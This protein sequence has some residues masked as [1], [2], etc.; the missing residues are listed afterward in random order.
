MSSGKSNL[1]Q[2]MPP[3]SRRLITSTLRDVEQELSFTAGEN[4]KDSHFGRQFGFLTEL[5][6]L[7]YKPVIMLLVFLPK[8]WKI[9][10]TQNPALARLQQF[11]SVCL[12][13]PRQC[14]V[15]SSL[16]TV[17]RLLTSSSGCCSCSHLQGLSS[18]FCRSC[19]PP[20]TQM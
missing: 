13:V 6:V 19:S 9:M 14:R 20:L 5:N 1:K 11:P 8:K 16:D 2:E 3:K 18:S 12:P 17:P 4:E 15:T 7:S 10:S